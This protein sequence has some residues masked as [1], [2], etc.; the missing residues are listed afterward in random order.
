L[1]QKSECVIPQ[2]ANPGRTNLLEMK[3]KLATLVT[4]LAL[5]LLYS[6][7]ASTPPTSSGPKYTTGEA[8]QSPGMKQHTS[9]GAQ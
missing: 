8:G 2:P 5:A 9:G 6:G 1:V 3:T 7:C 4:A